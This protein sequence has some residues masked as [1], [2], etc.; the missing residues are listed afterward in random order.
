MTRFLPI[1]LAGTALGAC[2]T[3]YDSAPATTAD[4]DVVEQLSDD[5]AGQAELGNYGFDTAGMD[6]SVD[7]GDDFYAYANGVWA[8]NTEIPGDKTNYGMFTALADLSEERTQGIIDEMIA[9]PSSRVGIA[10]RAYVDTDTIDAKG[11]APIEPILA[12]IDSISDFADYARVMAELDIVGVGGK[13]FGIFV[14]QDR[15]NSE[16]YLTSISQGG[17]SLPDRDY[18]L[19]LDNERYAKVRDA[20]VTRNASLLGMIGADNAQARAQAILDFEAKLAEVHWDRNR[21]SDSEATYNLSSFDD[22]KALA[23]EFDWD[24]YVAVNMPGKSVEEI[25]ISTPDSIAAG[26]RLASAA[27]LEVLKDKARIAALTAY[28]SV[29]PTAVDDTVFA[30][31]SL[32]TGQPTQ[33]ER[34]KR[35]VSFVSGALRDDLG[36]VYAE[37]Y[38]PAET[39]AEMQKLVD[40]VL[41]AMR[42]R[43]TTADWMAEPTKVQAIDKLNRFTVKIGYPDQWMDYDGLTMVEGDAFGNSL[44]ANEWGHWDS[45]N[46][47]GG[48]IQRWRWGMAPMTV[49]AYA[50]FGMMEIVF[51][52]SILQAP[53]FDPNADAAYNYGGI[54]AVIGHEIS[55]HFDDQGAK[56]DSSGNLNNWWTEA[57]YANFE[58]RGK[59]LIDQYALYEIFP[60]EFVDGEFTLG[61]NIGD[62][63][64]LSIAFDAYKASLGGK[65]A[66]VLDGLTGDQRFFLG[67]AQVWRRNYRDEE[68]KNRLK[69]DSHSPSIQRTWVVRNMDAWY[70]AFGV[71]AGDAMYLPP[72]ERVTVW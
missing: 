12:R 56:Y 72:E 14:G 13:P 17:T 26:V 21:R 5:P 49:N 52:A 41:V 62:L 58:A 44:R 54:G 48:P 31:T 50:N 18:Y 47:L 24:T 25:N 38:F 67:W 16:R 68:L 15:G 59:A 45:V 23:P 36:K 71:E 70:D 35:G 39:K 65:E 9:D 66:P 3:T 46:R 1:L 57:D 29:L 4:N 20:F 55:H 40:N 28:S 34:W 51:P 32:L 60:G 37:R 33:R 69:T 19:E 22:L 11:L 43:I 42:D 63:A 27:D 8:A 7:A 53:F 64:G 30:Y 61:E 2:A 6:T 10:Y